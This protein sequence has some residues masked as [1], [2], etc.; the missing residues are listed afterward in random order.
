MNRV[1]LI[2]SVVQDGTTARFTRVAQAIQQAG[3]L[4]KESAITLVRHAKAIRLFAEAQEPKMA[5]SIVDAV[6][7][8]LA[9]ADDEA[10]T[11]LVEMADRHIQRLRKAL[12]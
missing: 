1:D 4:P 6:E 10:T 8:L 11:E 3:L 5:L 12:A 2:P 7:T 9:T